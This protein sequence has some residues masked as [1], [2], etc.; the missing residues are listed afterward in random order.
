[1]LKWVVINPLPS[2]LS[3]LWSWGKRQK[4]SEL[5]KTFFTQ[6]HVQSRASLDDYDVFSLLLRW[7]G[8]YTH[9]T[10]YC[11]TIFLCLSWCYLPACRASFSQ[12]L[13]GILDAPKY[14]TKEIPGVHFMHM[15]IKGGWQSIPIVLVNVQGSFV[16]RLS[17]SSISLTPTKPGLLIISAESSTTRPFFHLSWSSW[18]TFLWRQF[19][20]LS[21]KLAVVKQ[22]VGQMNYWCNL[23]NHFRDVELPCCVRGYLL[24]TW[25]FV[26]LPTN[27]PDLLP[28]FQH[29]CSCVS[30]GIYSVFSWIDHFMF[31]L[32]FWFF[33]KAGCLESSRPFEM[34]VPFGLHSLDLLMPFVLSRKDKSSLLH[35]QSTHYT[36]QGPALYHQSW[37]I[38]VWYTQAAVRDK[39]YGTRKVIQRR[40]LNLT[41]LIEGMAAA[42]YMR[43]GEELPKSSK[44]SGIAFRCH[45]SC[46]LHTTQAKVMSIHFVPVCNSDHF[47]V[48]SGLSASS[49]S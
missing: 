4:R 27:P 11:R 29:Q 7:M 31:N 39:I 1:M 28:P 15:L 32:L 13:P 22:V 41:P 26:P 17:K 46:F 34:C 8:L 21:I 49:S 42:P 36:K 24:S 12:A 25:I 9:I 30:F 16:S 37:E 38:D 48:K 18:A 45:L 43:A 5:W 3:E 10:N 40:K 23:A 14:D 33:K 47:R 2:L 6:R 35:S 20:L 19:C 44:K